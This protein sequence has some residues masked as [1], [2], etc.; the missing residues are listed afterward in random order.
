MAQVAQARM[1]AAGSLNRRSFI[2][3]SDARIIMGDDEPALL[4]QANRNQIVI[5]GQRSRGFLGNFLSRTLGLLPLSSMN[6][7]NDMRTPRASACSLEVAWCSMACGDLDRGQ[8]CTRFTHY[9]TG[10][11]RAG[12]LVGASSSMLPP[13][14]M[15]LLK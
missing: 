8:S 14:A 4:R 10:G 3:G 11:G 7:C 15:H 1:K 5:S 6:Q 2:G 9:R 12:D 13:F